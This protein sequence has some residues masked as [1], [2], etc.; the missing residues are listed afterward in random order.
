MAIALD[1]EVKQTIIEKKGLEFYTKW[2]EEDKHTR[3]RVGLT[4]TYDMGWNKRSSGHI[5]NS[6]SGH[7]FIIGAF[8]C[9]IIACAVFSKKCDICTKRNNT[10]VDI[11]E[12]NSDKIL[13]LTKEFDGCDASDE[14]TSNM[15]D[16][17]DVPESNDIAEP[18]PLEGVNPT[19][20][21]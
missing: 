16:I 9:R 18:T 17:D 6:L 12:S 19:I 2:L 8:T 7:A 14:S 3:M 13:D 10:R 21:K 1:L 11:E 4:V 5:Y 15:N 20:G